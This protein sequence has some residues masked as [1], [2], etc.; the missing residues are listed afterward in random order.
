MRTFDKIRKILEESQKEISSF[1]HIYINSDYPYYVSDYPSD[2]KRKG[3]YISFSIE[4]MSYEFEDNIETGVIYILTMVNPHNPD[5]FDTI[6][7]HL[8]Y[9]H[10]DKII[11][12]LE[13]QL[14]MSRKIERLKNDIEDESENISGIEDS[15]K[16]D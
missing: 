5:E 16:V 15:D 1:H 6:S 10:L 13:K 9:E 8:D 11:E 14:E 2:Y 12:S 3:D 7:S 4:N